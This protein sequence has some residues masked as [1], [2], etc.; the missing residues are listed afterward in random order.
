MADA[1]AQVK[2]VAVT[3]GFHAYQIV[4]GVQTQNFWRSQENLYETPVGGLSAGIL[5]LNVSQGP[6]MRRIVVTGGNGTW[7]ANSA[8]STSKSSIQP[9]FACAS[10]RN[11]SIL[12]VSDCILA[13]P[14]ERNEPVSDHHL[15]ATHQ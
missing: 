8:S 4:D 15:R 7:L 11:T 3:G 14:R 6:S 13:D 5:D 9:K 10:L 1:G 2:D 12:N